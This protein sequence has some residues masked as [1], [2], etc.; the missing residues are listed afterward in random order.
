MDQDIFYGLLLECESHC[1]PGLQPR[2]E[3]RAGFISS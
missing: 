2:K 1:L 3:I